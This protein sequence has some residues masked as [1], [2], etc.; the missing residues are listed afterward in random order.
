[1]NSNAAVKQIADEFGTF[2]GGTCKAVEFRDDYSI[3][4]LKLLNQSVELRSFGSGTGE[5]FDNEFI[6][7]RNF[8]LSNL[9]VKPITVTICLRVK[10]LE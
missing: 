7:I 9:V 2:S 4:L 8:E 1:M 3:A 10:T 5:F 6:V